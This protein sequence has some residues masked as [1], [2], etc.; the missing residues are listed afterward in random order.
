MIEFWT[1]GIF[2]IVIF[3]IAVLWEDITRVIKLLKK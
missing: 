2:L 3:T 1:I